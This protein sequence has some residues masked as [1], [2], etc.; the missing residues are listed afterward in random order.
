MITQAEVHDGFV[1]VNGLRIHYVDWG[2]EAAQPLIM[3]HGLRSFAHNWDRV[4]EAFRDRYH[5]MALDQR[6][7]GDSD[8][9]PEANYYTK[10][11]VSDLAGFIEQLNLKRV[12]LA[13]H[14]MGG[15]NVLVY[16]SEHPDVVD[17]VV[18]E[19]MGPRGATPTA[20]GARIA[21]ELGKTPP[22]FES[23][24]AAEAFL[25][26]ERP[27]IAEDA[28]RLRM[29]NALREQP[30]NSLREQSDPRVAWKLDIQGIVRARQKADASTE[31]DLWPHVRNLRCPTLVLRGANSDSLAW[32]TAQEMAAANDNIHAVE[33]PGATHYVHDDNLDVFVAEVTKLLDQIS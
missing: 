29:A 30:A 3:L 24:A 13:G 14:S 27:N 7:R 28:L 9:D 1:K 20:A 11:Y 16:T 26:A 8:W 12:I 4:A 5:V 21:G 31:V 10:S 33:V 25:R 6:G 15:T 19:D 32:S 23:W 18:V 17:A 2:N 22:D